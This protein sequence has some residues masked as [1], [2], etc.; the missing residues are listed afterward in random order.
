VAVPGFGTGGE[1]HEGNTCSHHTKAT[2]RKLVADRHLHHGIITPAYPHRLVHISHLHRLTPPTCPGAHPPPPGDRT[3]EALVRFADTLVPSAGQPHVK[4]GQLTSAPKTSGC[5]MAGVCVGGGRESRGRAQGGER[6]EDS[7]QPD[8]G[9]EGGLW[10]GGQQGWWVHE[11]VL[12]APGGSAS[13]LMQTPPTC[14]LPAHAPPTHPSPPT[15]SPTPPPNHAHSPT[16]PPCAHPPRLCAGEEGA[17]HPP[18]HGAR[19]GPLL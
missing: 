1:G 15:H 19:R 11:V 3:K 7:A 9:G 8:M 14:L 18:L 12:H 17:R 13:L 5:N 2:A 10:G 6:G 4:H 16:P